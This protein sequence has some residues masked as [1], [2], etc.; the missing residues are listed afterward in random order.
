MTVEQIHK[1]LLQV[2]LTVAE[3]H[4]AVQKNGEEIMGTRD[5]MLQMERTSAQITT[6]RVAC[7]AAGISPAVIN[8]VVETTLAAA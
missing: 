5:A 4:A 6:A 7:E 2:L 3:T 1:N 8:T